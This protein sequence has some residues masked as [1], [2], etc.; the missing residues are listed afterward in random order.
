MAA[1]GIASLVL[2]TV[3]R[4]DTG[5]SAGVGAV[6]VHLV[7]QVCEVASGTPIDAARI[8]LE[9]PDYVGDPKEPYVLELKTG[10]DG[11]A[12][13]TFE[14][15]FSE[16]RGIPS[17]RLR[18]YRVRYPRWQIT[19]RAD[20]YESAEAWFHNYVMRDQRFSQPGTPP[21]VVTRLRKLR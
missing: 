6:D 17:G 3:L 10:P 16:T 1:I 9:D 11:R 15:G 2:W 8:Q 4:W 14:L 18:S 21:P 7:F 5:F 19:V 20:G 12:V 13:A